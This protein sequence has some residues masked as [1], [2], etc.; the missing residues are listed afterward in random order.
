MV[1]KKNTES[2]QSQTDFWED[3]KSYVDIRN[4]SF[5]FKCNQRWKDLL[6]RKE[7]N[8]KYCHECEREVYLIETNEELMRVIKFNHCAAIK[9]RYDEIPQ[10]KRADITVG[11]LSPTNYYVPAYLRNKK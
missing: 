11:M 2:T 4:C 6:K 1:K 9:V 8:I 7:K 3:A 5:G 10:T